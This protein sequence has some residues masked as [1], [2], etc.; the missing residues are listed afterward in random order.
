MYPF[1][2]TVNG[3]VQ[4][5]QKTGSTQVFTAAIFIGS[6]LLCLTR[7]IEVK[8]RSNCINTQ[9]VYMELIQPVNGIA[10]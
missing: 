5:L 4:V 7:K 6:G 9:S 2:I 10:D 1:I 3:H 8:H